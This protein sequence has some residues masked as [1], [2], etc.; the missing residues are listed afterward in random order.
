M[1]ESNLNSWD[2]D[3]TTWPTR[4]EICKLSFLPPFPNCMGWYI[5]A[6]LVITS[7][8]KHENALKADLTVKSL[9]LIMMEIEKDLTYLPKGC[10]EKKYISFGY[11]LNFTVS[12]S[13]SIFIKGLSEYYCYSLHEIFKKLIFIVWI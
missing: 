11:T 8:G 5:F 4:G 3:S 12:T 10:I 2:K 6:F 1:L 13:Y 9:P 7:V